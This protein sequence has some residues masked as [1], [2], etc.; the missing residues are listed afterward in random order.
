MGFD[1][2]RDKIL[3]KAKGTH[4]S[5]LSH[6]TIAKNRE[7]FP[8]PS[9]DL[10]RVLSGSLFKGIPSKTMTLIV[11]PEASFKSSFMCLCAAEAQRK[12]YEPW[13]IDTEG[14][15]TDEFVARW[16][17]NADKTTYIYEPFVD[18]ILVILTQIIEAIRKGEASKIALIID[19]IGGIEMEKLIDDGLAGNVKADQGGLAKKIKRMLKLLLYICKAGDSLVF[20]SGHLVGDPQAGMYAGPEKVGGGKFVSLAPD[21]IVNLKKYQ[22]KDENRHVIG[23]SIKATPIK[24]RFYP[25][26]NEAQI[27]INYQDGIN[28]YAGI[29]DL[30]LDANLV[31][32]A[33]AWFKMDGETIGQGQKS[34]ENKLENEKELSDRILN[35]I[36]DW[37]KETKYSTYNADLAEEVGKIGFDDGKKDD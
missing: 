10:N 13:I 14:A 6:S 19:S 22:I 26:F 37:L 35:K 21:I 25:P 9:Y 15:W 2:L 23:T 3:K 24:N 29:V 11:G 5:T 27:E 36:D 4:I 28:K 7:W 32:K 33:G 18:N 8:T 30:A 16:G 17:I 34:I 20:M 12:G 1:L 31:E